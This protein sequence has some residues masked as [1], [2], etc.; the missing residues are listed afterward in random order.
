MPAVARRGDQGVPHCSG[1]TIADGS[2]DVNVNGRP[3]ARVSDS[4]TPHLRPGGR[5]CVSHTAS[6]S[7]GSN[8]VNVNGR[9]IAREGDPLSSCTSIAQGSSDVFAG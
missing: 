9:A 3:V 4:S 5:R 8:S 6:I 1:Y 7:R 2:N